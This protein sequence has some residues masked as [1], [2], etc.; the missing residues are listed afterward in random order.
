M[1]HL[2]LAASN[3]PGLAPVTEHALRVMG[4]TPDVAAIVVRTEDEIILAVGETVVGIRA[5]R[6]AFGAPTGCYALIDA[7]G[8][9]LFGY[10]DLTLARAW[11]A[12][13][14]LGGLPPVE[15]L[16]AP[17]GESPVTGEE[18]AATLWRCA[19]CVQA[20]GDD[21]D[22]L[23]VAN[24]GGRKVT[25]QRD[26]RRPTLWHARDARGRPVADPMP[27]YRLVDWAA[28]EDTLPDGFGS[29]A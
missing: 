26:R 16:T 12:A 6:D 22:H 13:R 18:L 14:E 15:A 19:I 9:P 7:T 11:D 24:L 28:A 17:A 5:G 27:W 10:A 2:R 25:L 21:D 29:A 8:L 23:L 20:I 4:L 3:R 1:R